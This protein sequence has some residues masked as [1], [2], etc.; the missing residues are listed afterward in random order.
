MNGEK[1]EDKAT[2]VRS[3]T[4][5]RRTGREMQGGPTWSNKDT[6]RHSDLGRW[7]DRRKAARWRQKVSEP[8]DEIR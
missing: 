4:V 5:K 8:G 6:E 1:R 3:E 2:D 7:G